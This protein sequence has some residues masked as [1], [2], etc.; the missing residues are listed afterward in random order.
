[1]SARTPSLMGAPVAAAAGFALV[2]AAAGALVAAG[3]V[4]GAAAGFVATAVAGG[5]VGAAV[6]ACAGAGLL[7]AVTTTIIA[8]NNARGM[9]FIASPCAFAAGVGYAERPSSE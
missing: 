7:H 1:M 4:V 3:A 5:W 9:W 8:A 2:G 6:G